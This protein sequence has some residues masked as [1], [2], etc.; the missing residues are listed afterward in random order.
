MFSMMVASLTQHGFGMRMAMLT[1]VMMRS[2]NQS[3]LLSL[4]S[5]F[6]SALNPADLGVSA[7]FLFT[8]IVRA[9]SDLCCDYEIGP[10]L[11]KQ[12]L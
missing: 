12:P 4:T 7:A 9:L 11:V 6:P 1:S 5:G 2:T 3:N 10:V 8:V